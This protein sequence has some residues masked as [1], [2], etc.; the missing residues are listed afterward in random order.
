[1]FHVF[2]LQYKTQ[3]VVQEIGS[4]LTRAQLQSML[5]EVWSLWVRKTNDH[6][7][8]EIMV[9]TPIDTLAMSMRIPH[10]CTSLQSSAQNPTPCNLFLFF[11]STNTHEGLRRLWSRSQ[12]SVYADDDRPITSNGSTKNYNRSF[13]RTSWQNCE[14][15]IHPSEHS[16]RCVD[17]YGRQADHRRVR[18]I[19]RRILRVHSGRQHSVRKAGGAVVRVMARYQCNVQLKSVDICFQFDYDSLIIG[20]RCTRSTRLI[21]LK[22]L[23]KPQWLT[24]HHSG[25]NRI[26]VHA[27][28][29]KWFT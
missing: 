10:M 28:D 3:Q 11:A 29:N 12:G 9:F 26:L 24:S 13:C 2:S 8:R 18:R 21:I 7:L 6:V 1:M 4:D 19:H 22:E 5:K 25:N 20:W 14:Q 16:A 23:E 27:L 17:H 15:R